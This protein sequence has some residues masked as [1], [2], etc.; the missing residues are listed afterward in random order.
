MTR[1]LIDARKLG[2]GGI[3]TYIENLVDGLLGLEDFVSGTWS[4]GLLVAP[5][6]L[7]NLKSD[8]ATERDQASLALRRWSERVEFHREPSGKYSISEYC[9]LPLRQKRVLRNYDLYHSPHY[10]LP[11]L[12]SLPSIVTVHDLIH[13]THPDTAVHK[14]IARPLI[15]S[16]LKRAEQVITVSQ[17]SADAL[18]KHF[19]LSLEKLS[20][21]HNAP[22]PAFSRLRD[23]GPS[24]TRV[25][26][27]DPYCLFVGSDRPHKGFVDLLDIWPKL[28][29]HC[30]S[31]G[32]V[33]PRLKAVGACFGPE[34]RA[35]AERLGHIDFMG[36]LSQEELV[37]IYAGADFVVI[38]S[39]EEGFGLVALEALCSR[40]PLV[41]YPLP[42]VME[43]CADTAWFCSDFSKEALLDTI[44]KVLAQPEAS[45]RRSAA[46]QERARYFTIEKSAKETIA[47]YKRAL[48]LQP[49]F[50]DRN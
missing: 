40:V 22:T 41:S 25:K 17:A 4:L 34:T 7:S 12:G 33:C 1:L 18:V 16:A 11:F 10:T 27:A 9:L 38:P 39:K 46:G 32:R 47:V 42:S 35:R 50:Q 29:A 14:L 20:V 43:V 8:V 19:S 3:G 28:E 26:A 24:I 21:V 23:R 6:A 13:V 44:T 5:I 2:D 15:A 45:A 36:S 30:L 48:H 37:E 49:G 31:V